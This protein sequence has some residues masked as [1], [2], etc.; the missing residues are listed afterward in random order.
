VCLGVFTCSYLCYLC[1]HV[2]T[3]GAESALFS[4]LHRVCRCVYWYLRVSMVFGV[5][6]GGF[7]GGGGDL[8][9]SA[10]VLVCGRNVWR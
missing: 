8:K 7:W 1:L 6:L 2:S 3:W 5:F 9:V 4:W 10:L